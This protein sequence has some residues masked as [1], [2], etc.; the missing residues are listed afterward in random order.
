DNIDTVPSYD[1]QGEIIGDTIIYN[2]VRALEEWVGAESLKSVDHV[3]IQLIAD[4]ARPID[5]DALKLIVI[6][7]GKT[8][9]F[10]MTDSK[11]TEAQ[12]QV[13]GLLQRGD[14]V[15]I[16]GGSFTDGGRKVNIPFALLVNV[17]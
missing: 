8:E 15:R 17:R 7:N 13:I 16:T 9:S 11:L 3:Q 2:S 1:A 6:R 14:T 12:K 5:I 10:G 4:T